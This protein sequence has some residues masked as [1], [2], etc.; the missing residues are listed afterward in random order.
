MAER[1]CGL[2]V[3]EDAQ[4]KLNLNVV[5]VDGGVLLV[6]NFTVCADTSKGTRP[7][8]DVAAPYEVGKQLFGELAAACKGLVGQVE[9]GVFGADMK[10]HLIN[11]GPVTVILE[12][13]HK[14][15]HQ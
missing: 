11:D 5:Q 1:I 9:A 7:S 13:R 12:S 15:Y 4:G 3:F 6:P 2:R 14:A 8:F 10:V